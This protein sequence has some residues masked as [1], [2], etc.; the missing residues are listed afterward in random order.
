MFYHISSQKGLTELE[1]RVS[2]HGKPWVYALT[3]FAVGLIFAGRDDLGNKADDKFTKYGVT[4]DNIPE[5][6]ELYQ[7][8]LNEILKNKD[9]YIY[10]LEDSGFL[11]NQTS[12]APEWVSPNKTKVIGVQ[13]ITDILA[14]I[15]KLEA[16]GKFVI[17]YYKNTDEYNEFVRNR[18]EP[19]IE[20]SCE[21]GWIN[22]SLVKHY[23]DVV[24]EVVNGNLEKNFRRG[25]ENLTN[26]QLQEVFH[27]L[28]ND[29]NQ[30]RFVRKELL[31]FYPEQTVDWINKKYGSVNKKQMER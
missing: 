26:N 18:I 16:E 24:K 9:C 1:P 21:S 30:G 12:W 13:H 27:K 22:I 20:N 23:E 31:Y 4:K 11:P 17:H 29:E 2:T 14:E 19:I 15:K 3:N 7:G 28:D 8:C 25:F 10:E 5:V 6:F